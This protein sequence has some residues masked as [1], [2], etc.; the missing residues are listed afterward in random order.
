MLCQQRIEKEAAQRKEREEEVG[1]GKEGE[2]SD[3][4]SFV[5]QV[6]LAHCGLYP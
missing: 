3:P 5:L 1:W 4:F 6:P 2:V